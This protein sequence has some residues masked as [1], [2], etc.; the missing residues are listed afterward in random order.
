MEATIGWRERKPWEIA[1][2]ELRWEGTDGSNDWVDGKETV[3]NS[4]GRAPVG[5]SDTGVIVWTEG[6]P[7]EIA[8][9][10]LRWEGAILE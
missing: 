5:R 10:E 8:W 2:G 1:W 6:K 3:G 7:C 9:G 4:L